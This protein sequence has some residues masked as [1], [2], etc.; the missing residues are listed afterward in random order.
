M[1]SN[2]KE[3]PTPF[4]LRFFQPSPPA[5]RILTE[6][7]AI[8]KSYGRWRFLVL[9]AS[10][11]GYACFYLVRKNLP[12]AI[13]FMPYDIEALGIFLTLHGV[14]YGISK[15]ANGFLGDRANARSFL[16]VGLACSA[17]LNIVF[18]FGTTAWFLG[19]IWM[20]NGWVQGMG[21]PPCARLL[22]HWFTPKQLPSRMS[23]W[24][25][26]HCIGA[27]AIVLL[28]GALVTHGWRLCF[29]VP[30]GIALAMAVVM[31]FVLPDTPPSV[32]LPE[33]EETKQTVV[34]AGPDE[35]FKDVLINHVFTNKGV[36]LVSIA[37]FFVY[38]FRYAVF[39]W[40]PKLLRDYKHI[41]IHNVA[42]ML[43]AFEFF[44]AIGALLGGWLTVKYFGGR[45]TRASLLFMIAAAISIFCFWKFSGSSPMLNTVLL[46][47]SG[48]CIYGPQCLVGIAAA[49]M[50][51]KK[52]AATA[53]GLTGFFGYM[54]SL[55]SGYG[56]AKLVKMY[57]WNAGFLALVIIAIIGAFVF[58][59]G[60]NA[61]AHGYSHAET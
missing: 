41:E 33:L 8:N 52:A 46:C 5:A 57:G 16:V 43:A 40:G 61:P 7:A 29:F 27:M 12:M 24:N 17:I 60:W 31:W 34:D 11:I 51:T 4:W 44:G 49:N 2:E 3:Q 23:I 50:A 36:W 21:F 55:L 58:A 20:L 25:T 10:L 28:C 14:L 22:T 48:F 54:S 53:V 39:D 59:L 26:S 42:W 30:A 47:C 35:S 45:T 13:P 15:F 18:G 56:F 1:S 6:Q 9:A 19:M 38:T 32:G 37:N